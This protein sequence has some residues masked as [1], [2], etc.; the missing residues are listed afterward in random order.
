MRLTAL[1]MVICTVGAG[2]A[3]EDTLDVVVGG[4][5]WLR[6][7]V[8][9]YDD[10]SDAAREQTYKVYTHIMDFEEEAPITKGAGG[11]YSHHRGLFIGWRRTEVGRQTYDTWHMPDCYQRYVETTWEASEPNWAGQ[12]IEV[13]WCDLEGEPFIQ[14]YR[15]ITA[16]PSAGQTRVIDFQTQLTAMKRDIQL[17]GDS[18]HAGMQ[19][20][21][22]NEVSE[23]QET[24]EYILSKGSE[25][26]E[27]DEVANAWW[28][29]CHTQIGGEDYWVMHMTPP[30]HPLGAPMYSI[31][32]YARFG[33]FFEPNLIRGRPLRLAF[34][35]VVAKDPIDAARAE[36]IYQLYCEE[37]LARAEN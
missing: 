18:H 6:T 5:P 21:L 7:V 37:V 9:A 27:N 11:L 31:R 10:S 12:T 16:R 1:A 22:S 33:A 17:R 30:T 13:E 2:A 19:V 4:E 34:R 35:V 23:H 36:G 8:T 14:E 25:R 29:V 26:L 32:P 24:T 20:R 15:T 3:A 28:A